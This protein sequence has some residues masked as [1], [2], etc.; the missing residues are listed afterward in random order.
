MKNIAKES[1]VKLGIKVLNIFYEMMKEFPAK[2]RVLIIS[3]QSDEPTLDIK[4]LNKELEMR[5]ISTVVLCR[6]MDIDTVGIK[7]IAEIHKQMRYIATSKV[8]VLD[9]YN[10]P[11]SIFKHKEETKII[12][13]WHALGLIKKIKRSTLCIPGNYDYVFTSG[14]A[15]RPFFAE[16]FNCLEEEIDIMSLP[17]VEAIQSKS[18]NMEMVQKIKERYPELTSDRTILY[19]PTLHK[20]EDMTDRVERMIYAADTSEYNLIIKVHQQAQI[21][22]EKYYPMNVV[23]DT[24]FEAI[25]MLSIADYVITDYSAFAFEAA[26]KGLPIYFYAYDIDFYRENELLCLDYENEMPG[27]I[28][29]KVADIIDEIESERNINTYIEQSKLFAKKF[30][31]KRTNCTREIVDLI[32]GLL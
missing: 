15:S 19:A 29:R 13:M 31:E 32:E 12:Q 6:K 21:T 24:E 5:N 7:N 18:R 16:A 9:G 10:I 1:F 14:K 17:R 28:F 26:L 25:D 4:M 3:S 20:G 2:D 22:I 23:V 8:V 30:V 27:P 11:I